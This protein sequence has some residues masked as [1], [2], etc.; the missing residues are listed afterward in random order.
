VS[1]GEPAFPG[2]SNGSEQREISSREVIL[3]HSCEPLLDGN[4]FFHVAVA[5]LSAELL[6]ERGL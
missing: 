1:L 4:A 6:E 3:S 5:H 2:K